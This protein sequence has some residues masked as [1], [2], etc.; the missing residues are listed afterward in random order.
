MSVSVRLPSVG[1]G[2]TEATIVRWLKAVGD[3]IE[4]GEP[5]FE[6]QTAK[7]VVEVEAPASGTLAVIHVGE[8]EE[9][10][11]DAEVAVIEEV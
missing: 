11:V 6:I 4:K 2:V 9:A 7:S 1:M 10:E 3:P 8:D 5:L